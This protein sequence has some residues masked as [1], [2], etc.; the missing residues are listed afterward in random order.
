MET[1][2][3]FDN[4]LFLRCHYD[5]LHLLLLVATCATTIVSKLVVL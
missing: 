5:K 4:P 1:V 3:D 2:D